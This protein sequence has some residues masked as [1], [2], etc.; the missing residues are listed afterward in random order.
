MQLPGH[1]G[2]PGVTPERDQRPNGRLYPTQ[3]RNAA[4][5]DATGPDVTSAGLA[6]AGRDHA[7]SQK[8]VLPI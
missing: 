6:I 4:M 8:P 5:A 1:T 2:A 3:S 7:Q